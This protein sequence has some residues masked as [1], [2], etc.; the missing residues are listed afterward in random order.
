MRFAVSEGSLE[1]LPADRFT[2][3]QDFVRALGDEHFP[4]GELANAAASAAV[5]PWN[6]LS[7]TT[8]GLASLS[9]VI[10]LALGWHVC[11]AA[12][13][14]TDDTLLFRWRKIHSSTSGCTLSSGECDL[15][16]HYQPTIRC[17]T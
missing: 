13:R 9:T 12:S 5:G 3:A 14:L 17:P 7:I 1:K 16:W 6:R 4:Y 8:A 11:G 2:S 15:R 10:A